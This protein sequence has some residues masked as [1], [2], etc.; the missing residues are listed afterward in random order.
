MQTN[1]EKINPIRFLISSLLVVGFIVMIANVLGKETA[2]I[3]TD[4]LYVPIS[5]S[6]LILSIV[7]A[8]KYGIQGN[9][10]KSY[11]SFVGFVACWFIAELVWISS[12]LVYHLKPFPQ[13]AE[14]F[15]LGGYPL[16]LLFTIYYLKP[17]EKAISKKMLSYALMATTIF[18]VP[19]IYV[20]NSY[21][22]NSNLIEIIWAAI[23]PVADSVVL[24]PAVIGMTLFFKGKV[25]FL[26]SLAFF[27][28]ILN[29]VADSGFLFLDMDKSYYTGNPIDILYLWSYILF[30]FGIYSHVKL[31]KKPKMKSYGN[32][33][34]LK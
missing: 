23:Y 27:A 6:L 20:T 28:I 34:D 7:I 21:N 5:G 3:T 19:T 32:T 30:A 22:Q 14:W 33:E 25:G 2:T 15:Y 31:H 13:E 9:H 8:A 1:L 11:L 16:L 4:L 18:L 29:I 12:E 10:G 24:F 26:W 17:F